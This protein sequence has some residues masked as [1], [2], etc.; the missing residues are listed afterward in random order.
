M[1]IE[2][3]QRKKSRLN[4]P[5]PGRK[6]R[7]SW[8]NLVYRA[9][10]T[11][12]LVGRFRR[13]NRAR[14]TVLAYHGVSDKA[15]HGESRHLDRAELE[16]QLSYI[17][18]NYPVI[19]MDN[20]LE[21]VAEKAEPP[22]N[23]VVLTFDDGFANTFHF[24]LP[25]VRKLGLKA[26]VF[27]VPQAIDEGRLLWVD[28]L[29]TALSKTDY[30]VAVAGRRMA[31][32]TAELR[33]DAYRALKAELKRASGATREGLLAELEASAPAELDEADEM[34]FVLAD[35]DQLRRMGESGFEIGSHTMSHPLLTALAKDEIAWELQASA[36]KIRERLGKTP[37]HLAYPFGG[38]DEDIA[39]LAAAAG[40]ATAVTTERGSCGKGDDPYRLRRCGLPPGASR[41][42]IDAELSGFASWLARAVTGRP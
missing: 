20:L 21:I 14:V 32:A 10:S 38:Y 41:H 17:A 30:S 33:R 9:A 37:R 24:A 27:A 8:L 15:I 3:A 4:V 34:E 13:L 6:R 36:A 42:Y 23:A 7:V 16:S 5:P 18:A 19:G 28:R 40:Y 39:R 11:V 35:W 31:T 26:T 29:E 2:T 25:V 12:G 22:P 1:T